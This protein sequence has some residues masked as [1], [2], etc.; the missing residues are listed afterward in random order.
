MATRLQFRRGNTSASNNLIGY[1]GE[2]T[3]DVEAWQL[4]VHDAVTQG[5]HIIKP[6]TGGGGGHPVLPPVAGNIGKFLNTDGGNLHWSN[7]STTIGSSYILPIATASG[8]GGIALGAGLQEPPGYTG[9]GIIRVDPS[10]FNKPGPAGPKG[11]TGNQGAPGATGLPGNS[12]AYS[13]KPATNTT[14]GGVKIGTG[15]TETADGTISIP[16]KPTGISLVEPDPTG[17]PYRLKVTYTN[18]TTGILDFT[19]DQCTGIVS[20]FVINATLSSV[21]DALSPSTVI[22]NKNAKFA[23]LPGTAIPGIQIGGALGISYLSIA[24]AAKYQLTTVAGAPMTFESWIYPVGAGMIINKN[25]E[26]E[27]QIGASGSIDV[28]FDWGV[29]ADVN[30]PGGGWIYSTAKVAFNVA[31]HIAVVVDNTKLTIYI[32]GVNNY[33]NTSLDRASTPSIEPVVIGNRPGEVAQFNGYIGDV[34]IWKVARSEAQINTYMTGIA[35]APAVTPP[36]AP[37]PPAP[38]PPV[39][40]PPVPPPPAPPPPAPPPP[41]P[42]P[43]VP[44]P[45]VPPP[46]VPPPPVPPPPP[47]PVYNEVVTAPATVEFMTNYDMN[48]TGGPPNTSVTYTQNGANPVTITLDSGGNYV[49]AKPYFNAV[50][51]FTYNFTFSDGHVR[52]VTI[53]CTP[54][55]PPPPPPALPP[56]TY[57]VFASQYGYSLADVLEVARLYNTNTDWTQNNAALK[58][59]EVPFYGLYRKPDVAGLQA[60]VEAYIGNPNKY[61]LLENRQVAFYISAAEMALAFFYGASDSGEYYTRGNTPNK[62][63]DDGGTLGDFMDPPAGYS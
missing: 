51:T 30:L 43:P 24:N 31:S 56:Y 12:N 21:S 7:V 50:G 58:S 59:M 6:G 40:P 33:T 28:A 19:P 62:S 36:S 18:N 8:L 25:P 55:P 44:P 49:F 63:F 22:T 38:P 57:A 37:P 17:A 48:I 26:Y 46:P 5:G 52:S 14:L 13:L 54:P 42:P 15:F 29:G 53:V 45:P 16:T 20:N 32:N 4:R 41:A 2:I 34:R 1:S 9:T 23:K 3:V 39:P 35:C 27:V 11:K 10:I 60:W 61:T 47:A